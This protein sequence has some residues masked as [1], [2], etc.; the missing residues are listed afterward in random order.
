M[1]RGRGREKLKRKKKKRRSQKQKDV[2][3][4]LNACGDGNLNETRDFLR[5]VDVRNF[6]F[7]KRILHS[8]VVVIS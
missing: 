3:T 1:K 4:F 5:K 2:E 8:Y 6:S 7:V